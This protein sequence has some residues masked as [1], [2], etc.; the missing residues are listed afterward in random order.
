MAGCQA[1]KLDEGAYSLDIVDAQHD[2][3]QCGCPTGLSYPDGGPESHEHGSVMHGLAVGDLG[4]VLKAR[5]LIFGRLLEG[6]VVP[7][8]NGTQAQEGHAVLAVA[9]LPAEGRVGLVIL[10]D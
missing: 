10:K 6:E 3:V 7:P 8:A 1:L 4:L 9:K 5:L 2:A